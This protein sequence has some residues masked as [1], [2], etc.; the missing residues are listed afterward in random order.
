VNVP[1]ALDVSIPS[2][3]LTTVHAVSLAMEL[4]IHLCLPRFDS[5]S[6]LVMN[7]AN[8]ASMR[9]NVAGAR[10]W[11]ALLKMRLEYALIGPADIRMSYNLG[12]PHISFADDTLVHGRRF[13]NHPMANLGDCRLVATCELLTIRRRFA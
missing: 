3:W 2:G 12:R 13:L 6:A 11:L 5:A 4:G 9:N 7:D 1:G 8:L 10:I